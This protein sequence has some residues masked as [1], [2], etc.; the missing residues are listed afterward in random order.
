MTAFKLACV[1][2]NAQ[3]DMAANIAAAQALIRQARAAGADFIATPENTAFMA[4]AGAQVVDHAET[5]SDHP[6]L[7]ALRALAAELKVWLLIGSLAV[8]IP[9]ALGAPDVTARAAAPPRQAK[10]ANR[11]FLIGPDGA[12]AAAYNKIHMFD[13]DLPTGEKFRE[14]DRFAPGG[15]AC[16]A[17]TPWG[18]LGMTVC[19]DL[20]FPHLYR[21]LAQ[22]GAAWLSVP[23]SFTHT[24]GKAHWHVLLR[25]RAIENAAFVFAPA[26]CGAHPG[27]RRTFGHSLIVDPWG[28]V[29][30]DAGEAPGFVIADIDMARAAR[31]RAAIPAWGANAA[32]SAPAPTLARR[33]AAE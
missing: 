30:A 12:I 5:E 13:V 14:S 18:M 19:Y 11:S 25:A 32:F 7:K 3:D 6:A 33:D 15:E 29:L 1:Q 4:F 22:A 24:T 21:A 27:G 23:S 16:L 17:A 8:K 26:Q 31:A 28:E 10:V 9:G 2:L 20:R